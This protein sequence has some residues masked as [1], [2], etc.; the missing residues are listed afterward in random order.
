MKFAQS[1]PQRRRRVPRPQALVPGQRRPRRLA[2]AD[3]D[4]RARHHRP[5]VR[6]RLDPGDLRHHPGALPGL[7]RQRL[8]ADG[9][10]PALLP[11]RRPARAPGLP[12][13][14]ALAFI[15]AFIGVKLVLHA[16]HENELP[17]ING[18]EHVAV[19]RR[20]RRCS[21]SA[22]SSSPWPSPP[23]PSLSKASKMTR[24][25]DR[26]ADLLPRSPENQPH[27][28]RPFDQGERTPYRPC[29]CSTSSR[30]AATRPPRDALAATLAP[31][32]HGRRAR[33]PRATGSPS[34]TTCRPSRRPTRRC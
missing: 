31:G 24:G 23:R 2:D 30:S 13:A 20:S 34:T 17:F 26:G 19:P 22:S 29:P 12:L 14:R 21:A 11:A 8:R 10:A 28:P 7:H 33:L 15:L 6:A 16:L 27:G 1:P 4:H 3:R 25:G 9:P 5:A 18:G 32:P